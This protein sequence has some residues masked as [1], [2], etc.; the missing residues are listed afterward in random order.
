MYATWG[1]MPG[2][3]DRDRGAGRHPECT[4]GRGTRGTGGTRPELWRRRQGGGAHVARRAMDPGEGAAR[5]DAGWRLGGR[6]GVDGPPFSGGW[7]GR[8]RLRDRRGDGGE[9]PDR[10]SLRG[11]GP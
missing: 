6:R 8:R 5:G 11:R 3:G 2:R 10:I 1:E 4:R 9:P 7:T